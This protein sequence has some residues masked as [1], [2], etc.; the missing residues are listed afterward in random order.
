M[1]R[2]DGAAIALRQRQF[3][4]EL[5]V[6][7]IL[8]DALV[9]SGHEDEMFDAGLTGLVHD[10]LDQRAIDDRQHL[11]GHRL[12]GGQEAGPETGDRQ[13]GFANWLHMGYRAD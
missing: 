7:M 6:E 3:E 5:A 4:L 2:F 10:V 12:G 13:N 8:D 9:A 1:M 11:L